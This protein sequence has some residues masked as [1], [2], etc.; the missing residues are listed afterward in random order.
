MA[1]GPDCRCIE[2]NK[3]SCGAFRHS[4]AI[5][6]NVYWSEE[7]D[8]FYAF[9]NNKGMGLKFYKRWKGRKAGF[10]KREAP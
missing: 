10:P 8:N 6:A 7:A 1:H 2:C 4:P 9:A 5:P 3:A